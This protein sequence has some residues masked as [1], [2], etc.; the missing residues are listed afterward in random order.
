MKNAAILSGRFKNKVK[1][2]KVGYS[3]AIVKFKNLYSGTV[4]KNFKIIPKKTK[5]HLVKSG[6]KS[7]TV[8]WNRLIG[9]ATGYEIQYS[10]GSK[11][12]SKTTKTIVVK[13][14]STVSKKIGKLLNHNKYYIRIRVYKNTAN[15]K[16]YSSWSK[17][18]RVITK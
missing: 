7:I 9:D 11:F 4:T 3:S 10:L 17:A 5:I 14:Y 18:I 1:Q 8:K 16:V 13:K 2:R 12:S 6:K 15:A